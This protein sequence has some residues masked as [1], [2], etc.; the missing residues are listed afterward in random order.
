MIRYSHDL[1]I[2]IDSRDGNT[3][4]RIVGNVDMATACSLLVTL[5]GSITDGN[6]RLV[7]DMSRVGHTSTAGLCAL[8]GATK[9]A[10]RSGGDLRLSE[11]G[12]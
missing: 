6:A 4:A 12:C 11:R 5:Q 3:V 7:G 9:D 1:E 8:L 2:Q 10:R